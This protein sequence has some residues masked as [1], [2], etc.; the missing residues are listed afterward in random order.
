MLLTTVVNAA[1]SAAINRKSI[2]SLPAP[3]VAEES[4]AAAETGE[5]S[6]KD[7]TDYT[8]NHSD[9]TMSYNSIINKTQDSVVSITTEY[10]STDMWARNYVTRG[11]GSGVIIS[12]DGY[13]MTCNHVIED[14]RSIT[15]TLRDQTEYE[16]T[17]IGRDPENDVAILKIDATG[18]SAATYGDSSKL[19]VGDQV[20]AIGNPLGE[21][22]GTATAGIISALSRDL[23]IDGQTMNLLQTDAS[24]NPGNSGGAL[25]DAAGNLIGIV[26]AKSSGSDVEGLGFAIPINRAAEIGKNLIENGSAPDVTENPGGEGD[27]D[28]ERTPKIGITVAIVTDE[29]ARL[30][31]LDGAG[32]YITS[33]TSENAIKAGLQ[34][35]DKIVKAD[36]KDIES[37]EDLQ[38]VLKSHEF[39][40]S[41]ELELL[42]DGETVNASVVLS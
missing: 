20:V 13:I 29:Q 25:F 18:L 38:D 15:V 17:L 36:G 19:N 3:A 9:Q 41:V 42:R 12:D 6:G 23:T 39:G 22:S 40:D 37:F 16:A 28:S 1:I 35:L 8:L 2:A 32:L 10:V 31:N 24:I 33:V 34:E 11:A 21:L 27:E 30:N 26:V 7:A 4:T 5:E 14:A